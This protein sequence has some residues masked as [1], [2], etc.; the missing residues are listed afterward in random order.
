MLEVGNGG[1]TPAE[2]RSHFSLWAMM[3]SPL[4]AGN[5]IARMD[6]STR[7]ILLNK[8]VI[9]IDQDPLGV[10]GRRVWKD[11]NREVWV[12]PLSGGARA[13]L[14]FNRGDGPASIRATADQ[15]GWPPGTRAKVRDL[16]AHKDAGAGTARSRPWSSPTGWRCSGSDR[17]RYPRSPLTRRLQR[18]RIIADHRLRRS[19]A[20][21]HAVPTLRL[22]RRVAEVAGVAANEMM[23]GMLRAA[24]AAPT[25]EIAALNGS[26]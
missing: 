1:M 19:I 22:V 24:F 14:L 25:P 2:Y 3:A 13:L 5:D 10:Q 26:A 16:W 4:M 18:C 8:E 23:V 20:V 6:E 11:G 9:A 12:K 7:S 21:E 15:L 17:S